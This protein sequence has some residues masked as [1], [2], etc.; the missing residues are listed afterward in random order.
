[1]VQWADADSEEVI[2]LHGVALIR[3]LGTCCGCLLLPVVVGSY[4]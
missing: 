2:N 4:R 1:V 3:F